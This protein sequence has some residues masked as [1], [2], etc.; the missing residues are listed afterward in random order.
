MTR[1]MCMLSLTT[2]QMTFWFGSLCVCSTTD[3]HLGHTRSKSFKRTVENIFIT[4][5]CCPI[6]TQMTDDSALF[7]SRVGVQCLVVTGSI[8]LK[9]YCITQADLDPDPQHAIFAQGLRQS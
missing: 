8:L 9:S 2:Y 7:E 1:L 4:M 5:R 3:A 6:D